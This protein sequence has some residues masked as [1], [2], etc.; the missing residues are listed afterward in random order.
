MQQKEFRTFLN[1]MCLVE[2]EEEFGRFVAGQRRAAAGK[3]S[4]GQHGA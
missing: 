3:L 4:P 2:D 1:Q